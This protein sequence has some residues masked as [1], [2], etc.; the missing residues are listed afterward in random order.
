MRK[1]I[2]WLSDLDNILLITVSITC[3]GAVTTLI[4]LIIII[5]KLSWQNG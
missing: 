1:F 2:K 4:F 5:L 3:L